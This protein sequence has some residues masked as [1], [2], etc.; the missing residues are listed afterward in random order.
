MP[1]RGHRLDQV[2]RLHLPIEHAHIDDDTPIG[3]ERRVKDQRPQLV[4]ALAG[5]AGDALDDGFQ[6]ILDAD[7]GLGAGEHCFIGGNGEHIFKLPFDHGDVGI[8]EIDFVDDRDQ[9]QPLFFG[10][11]HIGDRLRLHSLGGVNDEE[12]SFTRREG[13]RDLIGKIDVPWGIHQVELV[14]VPVQRL[15]L[16]RHRMRLDGDAALALQVHRV[17]QLVLGFAMFDRTGELQE[18]IRKRCLSVVD[19]RDDAK[20]PGPSVRHG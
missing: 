20:V 4:G 15:V 11:M 3:I 2:A 18:A 7:A 16:H 14:S 19:V 12:C 1:I 8:R 13:T 9:L 10:Q 17:E 5:G 6:N